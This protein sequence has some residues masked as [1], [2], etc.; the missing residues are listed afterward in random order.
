MFTSKENF[1]SNF[2]SNN[3]YRNIINAVYVPLN[4]VDN[5]RILRLNQGTL[6]RIPRCF[7]QCYKIYIVVRKTKDKHLFLYI[8][9]APDS[10]GKPTSSRNR[11]NRHFAQ[12]AAARAFR[13]FT[14]VLK[15]LGFMNALTGCINYTVFRAM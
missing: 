14:L 5:V 11:H 12:R 4:G 7:F 10:D 3:L 6:L 13:S 8:K 9:G 15:Y 1:N 2:S